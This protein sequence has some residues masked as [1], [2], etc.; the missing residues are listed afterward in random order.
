MINHIV[1]IL[2]QKCRRARI[3][4]R[5]HSCT[6][7]AIFPSTSRWISRIFP[8]RPFE[9]FRNFFM[10]I[11]WQISRY[12][13]STDWR[14][15]WGVFLRSI[16]RGV[17]F[18][19]VDGRILSFFLP[20]PIDK[21]PDFFFL[22]WHFWNQLTNFAIF[23]LTNWWSSEFFVTAYCQ[24]LRVFSPMRSKEVLVF[25]PQPSE[26]FREFSPVT[27]ANFSNFFTLTIDKF[28]DISPGPNDETFDL[29]P[30]INSQNSW[31]FFF[32]RDKK[33]NESIERVHQKGQGQTG[34]EAYQMA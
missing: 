27:L 20:Q 15:L 24:N 11:D 3:F 21:F 17:C 29:F 2:E 6:I 23:L 26:E 22:D 33:E 14:I 5:G 34:G 30:E 32:S 16:V 4:E 10:T 19:V 25:F 28:R 1:L 8:T 31:M 18:H 7:F 9:K 13:L 12:F